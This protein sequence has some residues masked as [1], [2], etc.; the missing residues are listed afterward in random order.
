MYIRIREDR[1][2]EGK[3]LRY[4]YIVPLTT[5][6]PLLSESIISEKKLLLSKIFIPNSPW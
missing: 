5:I 2:L 6:F 4:E 1:E 3:V